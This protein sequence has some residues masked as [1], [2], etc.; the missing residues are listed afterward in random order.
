M[1]RMLYI[2]ERGKREA[3]PQKSEKRRERKF[4]FCCPLSHPSLSNFSFS[5]FLINSSRSFE[6]R[7]LILKFFF[8]RKTWI[9]C[10]RRA[11][12]WRFNRLGACIIGL[13]YLLTNVTVV[14]MPYLNKKKATRDLFQKGRKKISTHGNNCIGKNHSVP[15]SEKVVPSIIT[16]SSPGG[17]RRFLFTAFSDVHREEWK[18]AQC[19]MTKNNSR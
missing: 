18:L 7:M 16:P 15:I 8:K 2:A 11:I 4:L 17:V 10:I 12:K 5:I 14:L 13:A 1:P 6:E 3:L 9:F 19:S